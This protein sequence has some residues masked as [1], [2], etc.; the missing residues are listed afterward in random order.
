[1]GRGQRLKRNINW[2][3]IGG[4]A[5]GIMTRR[6]R[7][8]AIAI[9]RM[10][11]GARGSLVRGRGECFVEEIHPWEKQGRE[12]SNSKKPKSWNGRK[13]CPRKQGKEK[14]VSKSKKK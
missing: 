4:Q 12:K 11:G 1:M 10:T 8:R 7:K 2:G 14:A 3:G 9:R 6:Q 5:K 13:S